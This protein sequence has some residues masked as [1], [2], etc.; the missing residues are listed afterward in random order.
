MS[1]CLK[2]AFWTGKNREQMDRLFRQS[3]LYRPKW[4]ERHHSNGS[5]YGEETLDRAIELTENVYTPSN[6]S[7][8]FE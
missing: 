2:L 7:Q 1:M 5:T 8:I 3:G 6:K 4:D